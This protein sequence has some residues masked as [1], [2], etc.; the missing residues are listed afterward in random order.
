MEAVHWREQ[1]AVLSA[2]SSLRFNTSI[3]DGCVTV[4]MNEL[5]LRSLSRNAVNTSTSVMYYGIISP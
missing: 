4:T 1:P 2:V 3:T 5:V